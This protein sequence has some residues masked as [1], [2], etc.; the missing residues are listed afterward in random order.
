MKKAPAMA[1]A[2]RILDGAW[3]RDGGAAVELKKKD[4]L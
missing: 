3:P 2:R 4:R 1:G